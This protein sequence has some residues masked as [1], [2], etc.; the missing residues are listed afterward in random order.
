MNN[1]SIYVH[2]PFCLSKCPY[3]DFNSHEG[4]VADH[5]LWLES[6]IKEIEYFRTTIEGKYIKSIFFGGGTPSLMEP[7]VVRGIIAKLAQLGTID[8][9]T[10]ITLEAN[11]TSYETTKFEQF[12]NCGINRVSI[13]VQSLI[14]KDLKILGREHD[15]NQAITAIKSAANIF[16]RTSFDLIYARPGQTL[17]DWQQEL[18]SAAEFMPNHISLYQLTIEKGTPFYKLH[19]DKKLILPKNDIAA[20]MYEWT[21]SYLKE[22]G[23]YRYEISNYATTGNECRHN[24]TYWNYEE[25]LG[26]GPG[27]HSRLKS[28]KVDKHSDATNFTTSIMMWHAPEKW[29]KS[30]QE[31]GRG[32]QSITTLTLEETITEFFMM[33]LRL[34]IGVDLNNLRKITNRGVFAFLSEKML[35]YYAELDLLNFNE[36]HIAL[37]DKGLMLHSYLV[38]RLLIFG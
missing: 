23:Y 10:E 17:D 14:N 24:L 3:C 27:A 16:E 8:N 36:D 5:Q 20:D 7:L 19:H 2:W 1:I 35:K 31:L 15:K 4:V 25:Y 9:H 28:F 21:T 37:T 33:G 38:P 6:Y 30:V 11:P 26:I 32:I 29:L 22:S 18:I 12:R 13:G 34:K